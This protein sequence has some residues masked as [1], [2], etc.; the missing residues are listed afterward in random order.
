VPN[1]TKDRTAYGGI[2][3]QYSLS[4]WDS[5]VSHYDIYL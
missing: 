3:R 2:L 5:A 4:K 1:L